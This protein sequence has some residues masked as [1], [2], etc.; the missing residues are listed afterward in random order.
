A[1]GLIAS[2]QAGVGTERIERSSPPLGFLP[3][4]F[5][6]ETLPNEWGLYTRTTAP[7]GFTD[8][9][10]LGLGLYLPLQPSGTRHV[11]G[12]R[13]EHYAFTSILALKTPQQPLAGTDLDGTVHHPE[14]FKLVHASAGRST[15]IVVNWPEPKR[16]SGFVLDLHIGSP[17][18]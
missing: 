11:Y 12:V 2:G 7:T 5:G 13:M 8:K 1:C 6:L 9:K 10:N 18:A 16:G 14:F 17:P 15:T 4:L 3:V